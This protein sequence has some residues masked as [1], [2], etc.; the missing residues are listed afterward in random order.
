[1]G[2]AN[3]STY[4]FFDV[5]IGYWVIA[6]RR[7]RPGNL[8]DAETALQPYAAADRRCQ[9]RGFR[10]GTIESDIQILNAVFGMTVEIGRDKS[11]SYGYVTPIGNGSDQQF[12]GELWVF[13]NWFFSGQNDRPRTLAVCYRRIS[14]NNDVCGPEC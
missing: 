11:L 2:T 6:V 14:R 3:D 1:M 9:F 10:V 12:D 13:F 7:R 8:A 5:G 4:L